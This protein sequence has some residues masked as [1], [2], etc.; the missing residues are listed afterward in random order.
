MVVIFLKIEDL[1][2]LG[3][4]KVH[5]THAKMLLADLLNMNMLELDFHLDDDV[6]AEVQ[7]TYLKKIELLVQ[8]KPIQYVIGNVNFCGLT[9]KVDERVL[10]PR[11]ET[12][13]LV[14]HVSNYIRDYFANSSLKVLDLGCGSGAIGLALKSKFPTLDVLLVDIS[15]DALDV[16]RLN[17]KNLG[18]DVE[19][20]QSDMLDSV[21]GK[22]DIIVSNPPYIKT[23]EEIE[24]I[25]KNNEPHLALYAGRDGLDCYRKILK[26]C[27]KNLKDK[28]LIAFEIGYLQK[29]DITH[30]IHNYLENV[31]VNVLKDLSGKDRM[32]FIFPKSI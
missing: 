8:N 6:S 32:V 20:L 5:S 28:F 25:V 3:K 10:I 21:D 19:F 1:I 23:D 16:S 11:F 7:D 15:S 13:E 27:K 30:L 26:S 4:E 14:F 24:D 9:L 18:L 22:F 2:V 31:E 17:A 12:E 29:E